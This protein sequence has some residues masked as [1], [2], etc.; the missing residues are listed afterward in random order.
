MLKNGGKAFEAKKLLKKVK[1]EAPGLASIGKLQEMIKKYD[2]WAQQ[3]AAAEAKPVTMAQIEQLI[4]DGM[5]LYLHE[6]ENERLTKM[7]NNAE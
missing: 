7:H 3:V 5:Y 1:S 6:G 4:E 2:E